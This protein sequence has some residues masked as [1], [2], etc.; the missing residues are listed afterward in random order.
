MNKELIPWLAWA[1]GILVVALGAHYAR[2]LGYIDNETTTR[3]VIGLNGLMVAWIGNRLPKSFA[4][5]AWIQRVKRLGGW[6]LALSGVVYAMLWAFAPIPVAIV[7]GSAAG[8]AGIAVTLGYSLSLR[9]RAKA[10]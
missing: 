9:A 10:A 7:G 8:I 6:S 3:V 4:P 1:A 5:N 2:E